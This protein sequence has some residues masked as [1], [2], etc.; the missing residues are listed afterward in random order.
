MFRAV[1]FIRKLC[2]KFHIWEEQVGG[3]YKLQLMS[4]KSAK[5]IFL[6]FQSSD[7]SQAQYELANNRHSY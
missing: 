5:S 4:E 3:V 6:D 2:L 1:H 7:S